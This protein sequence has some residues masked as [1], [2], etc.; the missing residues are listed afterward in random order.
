[1]GMSYNQFWEGPPEMAIAYRKAYRLKREAENEALWL[2]GLYNYDA[3][4]VVLANAFRSKGAKRQNYFEKPID[5]FPLTEEEKARRV[6][7]E[8][9][10]MQSALEAMARAQKRSDTNGG[11]AGEPGT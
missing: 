7:E 2:Q 3:F 5:I 9:A 4:A 6:Q 1:M 10:K 11:H 8:N